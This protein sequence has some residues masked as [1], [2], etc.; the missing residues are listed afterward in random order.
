MCIVN[1]PVQDSIG[2][3]K[4]DPYPLKGLLKCPVHGTA[5]TAYGSLSGNKTIYHYYLCPKCKKQRHPILKVHNH[6]EEILSTIQATAQMENPLVLTILRRSNLTT[7][8]Y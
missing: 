6:I 1:N 2:D 5:V 7:S 4:S 3:D 8:H